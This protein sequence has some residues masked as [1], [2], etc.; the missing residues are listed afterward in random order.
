MKQYLEPTYGSAT[1]KEKVAGAARVEKVVR[2]KFRPST[3]GKGKMRRG[4][5]KK[6]GE[7]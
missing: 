6:K 2:K 1:V 4:D 7:I 5:G 3:H